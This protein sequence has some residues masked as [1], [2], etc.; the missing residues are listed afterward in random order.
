[1]DEKQLQL[2]LKNH[3]WI[4]QKLPKNFLPKWW[5][6]DK[7]LDWNHHTRV[8]WVNVGWNWRSNVTVWNRIYRN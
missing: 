2:T 1:M 7:T 4:H 3:M 6:V 8:S 5:I